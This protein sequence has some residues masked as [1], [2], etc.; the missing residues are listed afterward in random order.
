MT[1]SI[2]AA[3]TRASPEATLTATVPL[4]VVVGVI[5]RLPVPTAG[6]WIT[7]VAAIPE[8]VTPP[9]ATSTVPALAPVIVIVIV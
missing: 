7:V 9:K 5:T 3:I 1:L 6:T 8:V 2:W 4:K